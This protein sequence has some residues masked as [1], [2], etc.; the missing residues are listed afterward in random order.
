MIYKIKLASNYQTIEFEV[1]NLEDEA[2]SQAIEKIN[3]LGA[4]VVAQ[5]TSSPTTVSKD[6]LATDAQKKCLDRAGIYYDKNITKSE[7]D[8]KIKESMRRARK[9]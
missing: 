7:A 4:K 6:D 3:E 2:I 1:E 8:K 5:E 9:S